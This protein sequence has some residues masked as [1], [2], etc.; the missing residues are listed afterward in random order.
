MKL[1][2]FDSFNNARM[3][4]IIQQFLTQSQENDAADLQSDQEASTLATAKPLCLSSP[5]EIAKV[6][7]LFF[8]GARQS[9]VAPLPVHFGVSLDEFSVRTGTAGSDLGDALHQAFQND[10]YLLSAACR[11]DGRK[12]TVVVSF[13]SHVSPEEQAKAYYHAI[14]LSRELKARGEIISTDDMLTAESIAREELQ[15]S[16]GTF[17]QSCREAGWDLSKTE[18]Q[19]HG[20]ELE[21]I[22]EK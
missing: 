13:L 8:V 18:L 4:L 16:W 5:Q 9:I 15:R 11:D 3:N 2:A 19:S 21:V 10:K 20:Y 22:E 17:S 14:L 12:P 7:P 1:I 6:E